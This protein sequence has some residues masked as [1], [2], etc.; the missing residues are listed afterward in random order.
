[1]IYIQ[2]FAP[3]VNH[4]AVTDEF[5]LLFLGI[6]IYYFIAILEQKYWAVGE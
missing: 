4:R 3:I 5:D 6:Q 1:M 2:I